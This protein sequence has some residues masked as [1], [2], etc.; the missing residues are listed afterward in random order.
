MIAP[1][2]PK[3]C[4]ENWEQMTPNEKGRFCSSCSKT[5]ID[6]TKPNSFTE[7]QDFENVCGRFNRFEPQRI[8]YKKDWYHRL[9]KLY[10]NT[11]VAFLTF[12]SFHLLSAF[13]A[14][15]QESASNWLNVSDRRGTIKV[16]K[17]NERIR[18]LIITGRVTDKTANEPV[19]FANVVI[20]QN[21]TAIAYTV[22]DIDGNYML[23]IKRDSSFSETIDLI[24]SFVGYPS[25]NI[26]G[27]PISMDATV[28]DLALIQ[29]ETPMMG[30]SVIKIYC[31]RAMDPFEDHS[32]TKIGGDDIRNSPYRH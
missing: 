27:I 21:D 7:I 15:A 24:V 17:V 23:T 32:V 31:P 22:T 26:T 28:L 12:I 10:R 2:I 18:D 4:H 3:P 14:K 16:K 19:P 20:M 30:L 9:P 1:H 5:V 6:F 13:Q 8:T 29:M 11:V 25:L